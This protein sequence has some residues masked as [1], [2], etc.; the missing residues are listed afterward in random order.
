MAYVFFLVAIIVFT[1][2]PMQPSLTARVEG[3][4]LSPLLIHPAM[5]IHPPLVFLGYAAWGSPLCLSAGGL[6]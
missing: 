6:E 4:G 5:L 1:A 2:D 3:N